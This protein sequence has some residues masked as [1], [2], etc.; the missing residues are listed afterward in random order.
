MAFIT[1]PM[2]PLPAPGRGNLLDELKVALFGG[3]RRWRILNTDTNEEIE[4]EFP[5]QAVNEEV[6]SVWAEL[7]PPG[8]PQP[9][10]QWVRGALDRITFS[11]RVWS[12]HTL[13]DVG[14]M[15]D[16]IKALARFDA[17]LGRPPICIFLWGGDLAMQCV[18]ETVGGVQWDEIRGDGKAR[19]AVFQIT[20][21]RYEP[22]E[23]EATD[24][25]QI[26]RF[27]LVRGAGP[28]D[29]YESIAR[30]AYGDAMKGVWLR[31]I[32]AADPS[33]LNKKTNSPVRDP[34]DAVIPDEER[35]IVHVP[36]PRLAANVQPGPESFLFFNLTDQSSDQYAL[37]KNAADARASEAVIVL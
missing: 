7:A 32:H 2:L 36:S 26:P 15:I 12:R 37:V 22:F 34:L 1:R 8:R 25:I 31:Q 9:V 18:V 24:T 6:A 14:E 5:P 30:R 3:D 4:G 29:T 13:E 17:E 10:L 20:L 21:L 16:Q 11:A 19:G 35:T 33:D 23:Q 28:G 27:S